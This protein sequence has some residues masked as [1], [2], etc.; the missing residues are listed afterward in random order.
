M[1]YLS[2]IIS[3]KRI[4]L[5]KR[6]AYTNQTNLNFMFQY[7]RSVMDSGGK[8]IFAGNGGSFSIAQHISAEFTGSFLK[9]RK[10]LPSIVLGTNSPSLTAIANDYGYEN[11]FSRELS[12]LGNKKDVLISMSVSGN[13]P[14]ILKALE[15][16]NTMKIEN[17][18]LTSNKKLSLSSNTKIINI[19]SSET[20]L[21]QELHFSI[22]HQLCEF[23]EESY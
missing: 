15:Q 12:S 21:V 22:L 16:A 8:I 9:E 10:S 14:N 11:I 4:E 5:Y 23:I 17:F 18:L 19:P 1:K 6:F 20:A 7:S 2:N 13:S 3:E